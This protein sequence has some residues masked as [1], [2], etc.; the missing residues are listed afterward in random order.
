MKIKIIVSKKF[1][2]NLV[3]VLNLIRT[4]FVVSGIA[5]F[6]FFACGYD[7]PDGDL[8]MKLSCYSLG[9]AFLG[10]GLEIFTVMVLLKDNE[11]MS[12]IF[13]FN[14]YG[15]RSKDHYIKYRQYLR[16]LE[17]EQLYEEEIRNKRMNET[18]IDYNMKKSN[19]IDVDFSRGA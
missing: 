14:F 7:G 5:S 16:E 2:Q 18:Q 12:T 6:L 8:C 1:R 15:L 10:M 9:L 13:D 4:I 11:Y 17:E 3:M 19:I